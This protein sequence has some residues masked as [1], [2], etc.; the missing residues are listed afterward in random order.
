ML[1][2]ST[3]AENS[4]ARKTGEVEKE[5]AAEFWGTANG[6]GVFWPGH[7]RHPLGLEHTAQRGRFASHSSRKAGPSVARLVGS[8]AAGGNSAA[9]SALREDV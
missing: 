7:I 5:R 8:G 1:Q 4:A 6:V 9:I 2:R 3:N